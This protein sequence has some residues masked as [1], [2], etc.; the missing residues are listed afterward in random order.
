M[1]VDSSACISALSTGNEMCE[2]PILW[3]F[4]YAYEKSWYE[5]GPRD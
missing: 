2:K 4:S 1:E 5:K 3:K